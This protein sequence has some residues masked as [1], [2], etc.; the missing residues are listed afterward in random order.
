MPHAVQDSSNWRACGGSAIKLLCDM[1]RQYRGS[2]NGDLCASMSIL[3]PMGWTRPETINFALRKQR[4]Y[5]LLVLTRQGDLHAASLYALTRTMTD[6]QSVLARYA[7]IDWIFHKGGTSTPNPHSKTSKPAGNSGG[8]P[9][10]TSLQ[11]VESGEHKIFLEYL[12]SGKRIVHLR[13]LNF[14]AAVRELIRGG[15]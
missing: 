15:R 3:K 2:N 4:H 5:R 1:A 8:E 13:S 7:G 6:S 9:R 12:K 11:L 14:R 10:A